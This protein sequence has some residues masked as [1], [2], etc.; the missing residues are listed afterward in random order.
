MGV[1]GHIFSFLLPWEKVFGEFY[2]KFEHGDLSEWLLSPDVLR[3][4]VRVR[5][6]RG[7]EDLVQ[8]FT[9]LQVRSAI[10]KKLT[11]ENVFGH[12]WQF[13]L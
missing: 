9:D 8:K 1:R 4:I 6:V 10:V 2:A 7:P 5:L 3:H 12:F 13:F 11:M